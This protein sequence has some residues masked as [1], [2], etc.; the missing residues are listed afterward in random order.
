MYEIL[1]K[2]SFI[3]QLKRLENDVMELALKRIDL[4]KNKNNHTAI[5]VHKLHG[6]FAGWCSFSV[7]YKIRIIFRFESNSKIVLLAI[8][9]HDIYK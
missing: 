1:I 7:D 2:P 8:D 3:K 6:R 5:K 9:D 4:L